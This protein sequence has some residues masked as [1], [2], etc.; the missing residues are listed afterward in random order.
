MHLSKDTLKRSRDGV[1]MGFEI[2]KTSK[3]GLSD[4]RGE[5]FIKVEDGPTGEVLHDLHLKN[6]ITSDASILAATL[7][8]DPT[9]RLNGFNM[10][11]VG[12]GATGS[13]LSPDA[14][15][16][17]QRK[18]N[19]EITRKAWSTTVFRDAGGNA[20]AIPTNIVDFTCTFD[21][22]EAVGPLNEMGIQSTISN[23]P[24]IL[25]PNP[26]VYPT[27]DVTVD[28]SLYDILGNY[29]TFSVISIPATARFTVTWRITF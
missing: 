1:N 14:P 9:S 11:S 25:N 15:D 18:L 17:A 23:N 5:V 20:V 27:R 8:R 16:P 12:T 28:L 4:A 7:F 26:N 21:E 22:G 10:L 29:L 2:K 6:V 13:L 24:L 19:S 3:M